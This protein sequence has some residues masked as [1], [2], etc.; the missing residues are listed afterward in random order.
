MRSAA[1]RFGQAY[2]SLPAILPAIL[3]TAV[4]VGA[5]MWFVGLVVFYIYVIGVHGGSAFPGG[6]IFWFQ[7]ASGVGE[8]LCIGS[9]ATLLGLF[10][11]QRWHR[12]AAPLDDS[13]PF[14][15]A[16]NEPDV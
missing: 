15:P 4:I 6:W 14:E 1:T 10:V 7:A 16:D 8:A 3:L 9:A 12:T 13:H 2:L 11:F 5:L